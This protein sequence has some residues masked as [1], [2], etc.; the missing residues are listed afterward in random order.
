[1]FFNDR[2]VFKVE[3]VVPCTTKNE[4]CGIDVIISTAS[5]FILRDARI[6]KY[7]R[8]YDL[9]TLPMLLLFRTNPVY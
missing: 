1:M 7:T 9:E 8:T 6:Y 3:A 5:P 2:N 4:I